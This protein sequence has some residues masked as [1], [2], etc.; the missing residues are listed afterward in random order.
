MATTFEP[1]FEPSRNQFQ[2]DLDL[3]QSVIRNKD[4]I[5]VNNISNKLIPAVQELSDDSEFQAYAQMVE[6]SIARETKSTMMRLKYINQLRKSITPDIPSTEECPSDILMP[7]IEDVTDTEQSILISAIADGDTELLQNF[8]TDLEPTK[9]NQLLRTRFMIKDGSSCLQLAIETEE[10]QAE[11]FKILRL[12]MSRDTKREVAM[13]KDNFGDNALHTACQEGVLIF[14]Q[15]LLANF[16]V[17]ERLSLLVEKN[18]TGGN[19]LRVAAKLDRTDVLNFLLKQLSKNP[20]MLRKAVFEECT[21]AVDKTVGHALVTRT[22]DISLESLRTLAEYMWKASSLKELLFQSEK[23]HT[24]LQMLLS[25]PCES[26]S[27]ELLVMAKLVLLIQLADLV[28][29][30]EEMMWCCR[31]YTD[32]N[33]ALNYL[34]GQPQHSGVLSEYFLQQVALNTSK[35]KTILDYILL[36]DESQGENAIHKAAKANN[37]QLLHVLI[38][39]IPSKLHMQYFLKRNNSGSTPLHLAAYNTNT[40]PVFRR[41]LKYFDAN[42]RHQLILDTDM[43]GNTPV[44]IAF[45]TGNLDVVN[46]LL[47]EDWVPKRMIFPLM[48]ARNNVGWSIIHL[49]CIRLA[50]DE[51]LESV[52]NF[53]SYLPGIKLSPLILHIDDNGNTALHLAALLYRPA[54]VKALLHYLKPHEKRSYLLK[55]NNDGLVASQLCEMPDE[56]VVKYLEPLKKQ[57]WAEDDLIYKRDYSKK[58]QTKLVNQILQLTYIP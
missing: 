31:K 54:V 22:S 8:L 1:T 47:K 15:Q 58:Q 2:K 20:A 34:A 44:L 36:K 3:L 23:S 25:V 21:A 16:T 27:R 6:Q 19:C 37:L 4:V 33:S 53:M 26:E 52:L 32:Y 41:I 50:G 46:C 35:P 11:I 29:A 9:R 51:L 45:I 55:R 56:I 39:K 14:V 30:T 17:E 42:Q 28:D 40:M 49:S 5:P 48:C 12:H 24:L 43:E 7:D 57:D 10:N 18:S 13:L 38:K